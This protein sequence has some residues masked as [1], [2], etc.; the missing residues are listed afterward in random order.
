MSYIHDALKRSQVQRQQAKSEAGGQ[1]QAISGTGNAASKPGTGKGWAVPVFIVLSIS[2]SAGGYFLGQSDNRGEKTGTAPVHMSTRQPVKP[3]VVVPKPV[4]RI[5]TLSP[6]NQLPYLW[7]LPHSVQQ[8]LG[9]LS[10]SIHVYAASSEQ[11]FLYLNNRE[12]RT[13]EQTSS[14]VRVERIEPDGAVLSFADQVF[15][16]PRPR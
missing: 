7:E 9:N 3:E 14:G 15:R 11:R 1:P 16:L 13:G 10:V 8:K 5:T 6:Y 2:L 4:K 12:Y